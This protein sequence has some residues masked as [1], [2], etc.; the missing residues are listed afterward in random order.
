MMTTASLWTLY[1]RLWC[2]AAPTS[3]SC[4]ESW[5]SSRP[6]GQACSAS[7]CGASSHFASSGVFLHITAHDLEF[8]PLYPVGA[9]GVVHTKIAQLDHL[10]PRTVLFQDTG[11]DLY[12][13]AGM[14]VLSLSFFTSGERRNALEMLNKQCGLSAWQAAPLSMLQ[15]WQA[16]Q[17]SNYEYL[18]YLNKLASRSFDDLSQYPVFPWVLRCYDVDRVDLQDSRS[19]RDLSKPAG[20]LNK[21]KLDQLIAR[22]RSL[23]EMEE[24]SYLFPTHYS[25]S[26]G[27]AYYCVRSHPEYML[28]LQ[29][30]KLD[31]P[32]RMFESI[33]G[34][35]ES[36]LTNGAD[37]KELIP[38]FF[39]PDFEELAQYSCLPLGAKDSGEEVSRT[40][41][42]P[43]WAASP[44]QFIQVHTAALESEYVSAHLHL[45]IDLIFGAKQ[46]GSAAAEAFNTFHPSCYPPGIGTRATETKS[47]ALAS[48]YAKEFGVVPAKLFYTPHPSRNAEGSHATRLEHVGLTACVNQLTSAADG[49]AASGL[50]AV[51]AP[52]HPPRAEDVGAAASSCCTGQAEDRL[53]LT[54]RLQK[55]AQFATGA[56]AAKL[57]GLFPASRNSATS[58]GSSSF[59]CVIVRRDGLCASLFDCA[60]GERMRVFPDFRFPIHALICVDTVALLVTEPCTFVL[61]VAAQAIVGTV[62]DMLDSCVRCGRY[63]ACHGLLSLGDVDG[64]LLVWSL[65][66]GPPVS[67]ALRQSPVM[68]RDIPGGIWVVG[69]GDKE[70]VACANERGDIFLA[71]RDET[72]L[73]FSVHITGDDPLLGVQVEGETVVVFFSS[74]VQCY[75][76]DGMLH[77]QIALPACSGT[78][79]CD[80]V[81]LFSMHHGEGTAT[82]VGLYRDQAMYYVNTGTGSLP[83]WLCVMAHQ[84]VQYFEDGML[85]VDRLTLN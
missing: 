24:H 50:E 85:R 34:A 52:L 70:S 48:A 25:S 38:E 72:V 56:V 20:A 44:R 6:P 81:P 32:Q 46:D 37:A 17:V 77:K 54:Y 68:V 8:I 14:T 61:D 82:L 57:V 36:V 51:A 1:G 49:A 4:A 39:S 71:T 58:T 74:R 3:T 65:R 66:R 10:F 75:S 63:D 80:R 11:L 62:H 60:T 31:R 76:R 78:F 83:R 27:V 21:E 9:H 55:V 33:G 7:R 5:T 64:C 28:S 23:V 41:V 67:D 13:R 53:S 15:K 79:C 2:R 26:G 84:L 16:R 30:G 40:L 35:W 29:H 45:W 19:Y 73:L 47:A 22:S 43:A 42:L 18:L 12:N 59:V 69:R